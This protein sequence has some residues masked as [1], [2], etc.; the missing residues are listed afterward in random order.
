MNNLKMN[1]GVSIY[2][3]PFPPVRPYLPLE[4]CPPNFIE[5]IPH[6]KGEKIFLKKNQKNGL[7]LT[8]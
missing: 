1:I 7:S 2:R 8:S 5:T 3:S 4:K 6:K